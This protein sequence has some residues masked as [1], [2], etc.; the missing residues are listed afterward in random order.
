MRRTLNEPPGNDA[1]GVVLGE[2]GEAEAISR[3]PAAADHLR[4]ALEL[5]VAPA[6]RVRLA[7][8]LSELLVWDG[9]PIEGHAVL[10][11]MLEELGPTA[12][13]PLRAMLE[14]LRAVTAS[15]DRRLVG[16]VEPRLPLLREHAVA[17]GQAGRG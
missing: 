4:E 9:R 1:R 8:I 12:A 3:D 6:I 5:V 7:R 15:I 10:V 11:R 13:P 16:E 17:A 14:T 2:L